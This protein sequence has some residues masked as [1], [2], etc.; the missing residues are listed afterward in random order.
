M[1]NEYIFGT[2]YLALF[3]IVYSIIHIYYYRLYFKYG[4]RD[5]H[6]QICF[7]R[8]FIINYLIILPLCDGFFFGT[9]SLILNLTFTIGFFIIG[10]YAHYRTKNLN[11]V[12]PYGKLNWFIFFL[13]MVG[14]MVSEI[15]SSKIQVPQSFQNYEMVEHEKS[16]LM[17]YALLKDK[18]ETVEYVDVK[19]DATFQLMLNTFIGKEKIISSK[20]IYGIDI[21]TTEKYNFLIKDNEII[22]I[23][24]VDNIDEFVHKLNW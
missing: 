9:Q 5:Y 15:L 22:K 3:V 21:K 12:F 2:I 13:A 10:L 6:Y 20:N 4:K 24:A 19:Y 11:D 8:G 7:F 23:N 14:F 17:K 16:F 18:D 1:S